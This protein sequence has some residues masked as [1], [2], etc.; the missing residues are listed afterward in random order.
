[1]EAFV[2]FDRIQRA[3]LRLETW[4]YDAGRLM[5]SHNLIERMGRL[6]E[7]CGG[8]TEHSLTRVNFKQ[9]RKKNP[10]LKSWREAKMTAMLRLCPVRP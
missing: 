2:R 10:T 7:E 5:H 6:G 9:Q 4:K 3:L 8:S 1:M